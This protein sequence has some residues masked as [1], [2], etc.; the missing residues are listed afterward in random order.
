MTG[1]RLRALW[2]NFNGSPIVGGVDLDV[3]AGEWVGLLGPNGAGK[4][5]L[6][7]AVMGLVP[8]R[9]SITFDGEDLGEL[10]P[11]ARA[12]AIATVPQRPS[13]P[14]DMTAGDY[15]LLGR[16]PHISYFGT[17]SRADF[18]AARQA[19]ADLDLDG[20]EGRQLGT[21]S[22]GEL[23]RVI[24]ARALAQEAPVLLLDEPTTALDVG[25]QQAV[26]ELVER[27]RTERALTV[28]SALHDLTLAAQFC[29]R[30]VL[31]ARGK[32]VAEGEAAAV[33]TEDSIL[34]HYGASVR[35]LR[36]PGGGVVV[37][38]LRNKNRLHSI[39]NGGTIA[40]S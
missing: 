15:I 18:D 17:E 32:L 35:V 40:R 37:I 6:L 11:R 38:P 16:T 20:Y 28:I 4:T 10:H 9:G 27:L 34:Q 19:V 22:G 1:L 23:Q 30:L 36:A 3:A 13:M 39:E 7:R 12:R 26:L 31:M 14:S 8:S 29:D 33:L 5:T 2:V 25:H 21:L 24:L